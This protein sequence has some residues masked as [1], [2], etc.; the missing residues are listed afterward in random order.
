MIVS[1]TDVT[2]LRGEPRLQFTWAW[3]SLA[4]SQFRVPSGLS[5]GPVHSPGE[6]T[7]GDHRWQSWRAFVSSCVSKDIPHT[8]VLLGPTGGFAR[9]KGT[10]VALSGILLNDSL[11]IC[12]PFPLLP[13]SKSVPIS[14]YP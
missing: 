12:H 13:W 5:A 2:C 11:K 7:K 8:H 10:C 3:L 4:W 1:H 14:P 9:S 6:C